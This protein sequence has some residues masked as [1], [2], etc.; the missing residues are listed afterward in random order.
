MGPTER[1]AAYCD[2]RGLTLGPAL[3]G[4]QVSVVHQARTRSGRLVVVK[5]AADTTSLVSEAAWL[6][7]HPRAPQVLDLDGGVLVLSHIE[8][9]LLVEAPPP[10]DA[11]REAEWLRLAQ[12]AAGPAADGD[13]D[14]RARY[15]RAFDHVVDRPAVRP[16][17]T[18]VAAAWLAWA[19]ALDSSR[20]SAV[21]LDVILKNTIVDAD[22]GW[23]A[24][25]PMCTRA[26]DAALWCPWVTDR[27]TRPAGARNLAAALEVQDEL[28]AAAPDPD[29]TGDWMCGAL[30]WTLWWAS[31]TSEHHPLVVDL[32]GHWLRRWAER[33]PDALG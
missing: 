29:G 9:R 26:P 18:R 6:E 3:T 8:G 21:P 23:W 25:D 32:I 33:H 5:T 13:E 10:L 20:W 28:L 2:T 19:D 14:V 1:I 4:G 12:V 7:R 24:I 16:W 22:G 15:R 31:P 17:P 11:V 27:A 30:L